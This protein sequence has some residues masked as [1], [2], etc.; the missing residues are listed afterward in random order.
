M[1]ISDLGRVIGII[2]KMKQKIMTQTVKT[3]PGIGL[4]WLT[5]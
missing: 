1:A 3:I 5:H 2:N 4:L